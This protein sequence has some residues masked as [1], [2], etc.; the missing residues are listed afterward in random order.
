M[1]IGFVG[2]VFGLSRIRP[3][4]QALVFRTLL[5]SRGMILRMWR[6]LYAISG[7]YDVRSGQKITQNH[8]RLPPLPIM[9]DIEAYT[10][11]IVTKSTPTPT[12]PAVPEAN[13]ASAVADSPAT[14]DAVAVSAECF[15]NQ[16]N[17]SIGFVLRS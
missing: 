11:N 1:L 5:P 3:F 14:D 8:T 15:Y 17:R 4:P 10:S 6:V 2:R 12:I 16:R 13:D 7:H 9:S